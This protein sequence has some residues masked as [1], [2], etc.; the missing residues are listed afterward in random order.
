MAEITT[1]LTAE[2]TAALAEYGVTD[3]ALAALAKKYAGMRGESADDYRA[4]VAGIRDTR[5]LRVAVETKRKELK[6]DSLAWGRTVDGEAK[7]ITVALDS[8]EQPMKQ[9]KDG[10]DAERERIKAEKIAAEKARVAAIQKRLS[11]IRNIVLQFP[12]K[13]SDELNEL[14]EKLH[15]VELTVEDFAEF[16]DEAIDALG[17]VREQIV[18]ATDEAEDAEERQRLAVAA[19]EA[20]KQRREAEHRETMARLEREAAEQKRRDEKAAAEATAVA[21][22]AAKVAAEERER[23]QAT[24]E[25]ERKRVTDDQDAA[26]KLERERSIAARAE[27]ERL[28]AERDEIAAEQARLQAERE[29]LEQEKRDRD[30]TQIPSAPAGN[31]I[32]GVDWRTVV[33]ALEAQRPVLLQICQQAAQIRDG[34]STELKG[35]DDGEPVKRLQAIYRAAERVVSFLQRA[36]GE[37]NAMAKYASQHSEISTDA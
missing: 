6:A 21:E 16:H 20:E 8:I 3:E 18:I 22:E 30:S 5:E 29:A 33:A 34:V 15:E 7:R 27:E 13:S 31:D 14:C 23:Q 35:L 9:L 10:I 1:L 19:A 26:A 36:P 32:G 25:K 28:Q 11:A 2:R 24:L 12:G 17:S 4:L 37:I